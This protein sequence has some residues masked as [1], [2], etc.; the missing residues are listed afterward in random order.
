M[1]LGRKSDSLKMA[2]TGWPSGRNEWE[3]LIGEKV[4]RS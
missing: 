2:F 3:D 4:F 1:R